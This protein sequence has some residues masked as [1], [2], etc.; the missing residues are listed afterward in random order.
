MSIN[1]SKCWYSNNCL[2]L[3]KCAVPFDNNNVSSETRSKHQ[4]PCSKCMHHPCDITGRK[5]MFR[6]NRPVMSHCKC[7]Q[8]LHGVLCF[9]FVSDIPL[10][11]LLWPLLCVPWQHFICGFIFTRKRRN[12]KG[13]N[14]CLKMFHYGICPQMMI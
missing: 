11:Q 6:K 5:I 13:S 4:N 9:D 3:F 7:M 8:L 10:L 12:G 1:K 2:H 14:F